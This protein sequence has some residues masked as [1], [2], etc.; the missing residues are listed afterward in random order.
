MIGLT[1]CAH[2]LETNLHSQS[3]HLRYEITVW[4]VSTTR[5]SGNVPVETTLCA[6]Q[7]T[8]VCAHFFLEA[9]MTLNI[10][11]LKIIAR[12][13]DPVL[14]RAILMAF[15]SALASPVLINSNIFLWNGVSPV[16]SVITSRTAETRGWMRP[17]RN[18]L[19]FLKVFGCYLV[20]VTM[21]PLFMPT[22]R[23]DWSAVLAIW[24][25]K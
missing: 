9:A 23:P 6:T 20:L 16:I 3:A 14:L 15:F 25:Q 8:R 4:S 17:L 7:N 2:L 11:S 1:T 21:C 12:F 19:F 24:Y 13:W 10:F 18:D 22:K 5:L